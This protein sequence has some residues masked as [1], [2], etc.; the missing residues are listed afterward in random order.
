MAGYSCLIA[1]TYCLPSPMFRL[2]RVASG[3]VVNYFIATRLC[4]IPVG[5]IHKRWSLYA[6]AAAGVP[7]FTSKNQHPGDVDTVTVIDALI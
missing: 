1:R 6:R 2:R 5:S 3:R 4:P 7:L